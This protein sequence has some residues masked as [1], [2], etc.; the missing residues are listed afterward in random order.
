[1]RTDLELRHL[2]VFV[3]VVEVG[4]HT[5]AA[6]VLGLSQST[7]SE[8]LSALERTVGTA[9]FRKSGKGSVLTASGE[10]LLPYARQLLALAA[11][12]VSELAKVSSTVSG[13]LVV[14]AVES[15]GAYVLPG[16]LAALRARWPK[17][18]MDVITGGC[19]DIRERVASGK[20]D[21]GLL[22]E[23]DTGVEGDDGILARGRLVI[24][25]APDHPLAHRRAVPSE[26]P[27]CDFYMSDSAGDYHQILRQYFEAAQ[28]PA[29]RTQSLGTVEGVKRG[30]LAGSAALGVLP[31]HSVISELRDRALAEISMSPPLPGL[32]MRAVRPPGGATSPMV[33]DLIASL[34]GALLG[35]AWA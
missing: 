33:D 10:T 19:P 31:A 7:V 32:V 24:V 27:R 14:S 22:L 3:T 21:L 13:T 12:V 16:R 9:L 18:R 11:E 4:S 25:A 6:R 34:R 30:I 17:A 28:V 2:R 1:V 26:L 5:R 35:E 15:L 20:S 29:P 8:T 23:A